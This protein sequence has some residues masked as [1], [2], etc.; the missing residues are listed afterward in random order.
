MLDTAKHLGST[1][2]RG[3]LAV[4]NNSTRASSNHPVGNTYTGSMA[5]PYG[6]ND[7]ARTSIDGASYGG[8]AGALLV[9]A[10]VFLAYQQL[11]TAQNYYDKNKQDFDFFKNNYQPQLTAHKDQAFTAP[12][13]V[14]DYYPITG[15][16]L[17]RVKVYDEKWLQTRR[18]L[19]R[20]AIGHQKHVDYQ[21]YMIRRKAAYAAWVAGRRMED[22]R[23]DW[24]DDQTQTHK[25]QALNF[26]ISAGNIARQGLSSSVGTLE[27]AYDELGSRIGGF[28]NGL[29]EYQGYKAQRKNASRELAGEMS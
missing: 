25:V 5:V 22:A 23:K 3:A 17:A 12:W 8:V 9:A 1:Q 7:N 18:R 2:S 15:A 4:G 28:G 19:H 20:Y 16:S 14:Q 6:M 21:Y 13:Y 10:Q 27:H 11:Q 29:A 26:G 24:K